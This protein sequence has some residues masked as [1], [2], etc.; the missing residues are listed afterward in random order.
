MLQP[1]E[2]KQAQGFPLEYEILGTKTDRTEQIGNA[3]PPV[4]AWHI[5]TALQE[6]VLRAPADPSV[7]SRTGSPEAISSDD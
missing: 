1:D 3:V 2:L 7:S 5:A 4:L 6:T